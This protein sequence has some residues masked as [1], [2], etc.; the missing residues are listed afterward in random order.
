LRTTAKVVTAGFFTTSFLVPFSGPTRMD[1]L[2]CAPSS[3]DYGAG[4]PVCQSFS[5]TM[6]SIA[7]QGTSLRHI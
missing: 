1:R 4:R 7:H 6:R 3:D 2:A 5:K